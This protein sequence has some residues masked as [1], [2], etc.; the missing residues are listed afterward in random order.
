MGKIRL[1]KNEMKNSKISII[2]KIFFIISFFII[3]N[4]N[5]NCTIGS[6]SRF[7]LNN[8]VHVDFKS[9]PDSMEVYFDL[10]RYY[11]SDNYYLLESEQINTGFKN[12]NL[13]DRKNK[14]LFSLD[15]IDTYLGDYGLSPFNFNEFIILFKPAK[16]NDEN[17]PLR[18]IIIFDL[19]N[20]KISLDTLIDYYYEFLGSSSEGIYLKKTMKDS[21]N[22][23]EIIFVGKDGVKK[24]YKDFFKDNN[25]ILE[26]PEIILE[27]YDGKNLIFNSFSDS[28]RFNVKYI[29]FDNPNKM[30]ILSPHYRFSPYQT[31]LFQNSLIIICSKI[32]SIISNKNR[33]V[34]YLAPVLYKISTMGNVDTL[35]D[36]H[37]Y[38]EMTPYINGI[39]YSIR[40]ISKYLL[41]SLSYYNQCILKDGA[42]ERDGVILF[43]L[44]RNEL[45]TKPIKYKDI[46][47]E[48]K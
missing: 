28:I 22:K 5:A 16:N 27:Y 18:R 20:N 15:S 46:T 30:Y 37:Y 6:A 48:N 36:T 42:K 2:F 14:I 21:S 23:F 4:N 35:L 1:I 19:T 12:V 10:N 34:K 32:D 43:D 3:Q 47:D 17:N 9:N 33:V 26:S 39:F 31:T 13:C 44:E 38:P 8:I 40:K 7:V 29:N 24:I 25:I 41:I 45:I 11:F